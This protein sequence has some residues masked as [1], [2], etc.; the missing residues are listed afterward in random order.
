MHASTHRAVRAARRPGWLSLSVVLLLV[1][2]AAVPLNAAKADFDDR[3]PLPQCEEIRVD[4][5]ERPAFSQAGLDCLDDGAAGA[6]AELRAS[7]GETDGPV[8]YHVRALPGGDVEVFVQQN[9]ETNT[10]EWEHCALDR[11]ALSSSDAL[12]RGVEGCRS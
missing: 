1:S 2:C 10:H 4:L 9:P 5:T 8:I 3:E 12:L 11:D 7:F 6:G